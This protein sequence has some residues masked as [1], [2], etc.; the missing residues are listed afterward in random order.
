[1]IILGKKVWIQ[2]RQTWLLDR[3]P[4][5]NWVLFIMLGNAFHRQT[6]DF[7][8]RWTF[9]R[10]IRARFWLCLWL[11]ALM[12]RDLNHHS[13]RRSSSS[14]R[15]VDPKHRIF[16]RKTT[17]FVENARSNQWS[18]SVARKSSLMQSKY[19]QSEVRIKKWFLLA[20]LL[21]YQRVWIRVL[22]MFTNYIVWIDH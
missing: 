21:L 20:A 18:K 16:C 9:P 1:M 11:S 2:I 3:K 5:A 19:Q 17:L 4:H 6:F 8:S 22:P 14:I 10:E 12:H 15:F 7:P 13:R